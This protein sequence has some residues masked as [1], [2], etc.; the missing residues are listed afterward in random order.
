M[1]LDTTGK[2]LAILRDDLKLSRE[3][4]VERVLKL[5]R[6]AVI[7]NSTLGRWERD[8]GSPPLSTAILIAHVLDSTVAYVSLE[9]DNALRF[10]RKTDVDNGSVAEDRIL[11]IYRALSDRDRRLVLRLLEVIRTEDLIELGRG[12]R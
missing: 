4:V 10:H 7:S 3:D 2:R 8:E 1:L 12:D 6:E 11:D 9:T 5:D